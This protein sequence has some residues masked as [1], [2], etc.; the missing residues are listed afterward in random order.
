M[1]KKQPINK[2]LLTSILAISSAVFIYMF[3]LIKFVPLVYMISLSTVVIAIS[4]LFIYQLW[5]AKKIK[6][7]PI[8]KNVLICLYSL[9][10]IIASIGINQIQDSLFSL[11]AEIPATGEGYIVI[12]ALVDDPIENPREMF[13]GVIAIQDAVDVENQEHAVKYIESEFQKTLDLNAYEDVILALEALLNKECRFLMINQSYIEVLQSNPEYEELP[14]KTKEIYKVSIEIDLS[15][16]ISDT[17][18]TEEA[19]TVLISGTDSYGKI[20]TIY[21]SDVNILI[22]VNPKTKQMLIT[23]IPRDAYVSVPCWN[24]QK[25]KLTHASAAGWREPSGIN[26]L[27]KTLE[28]YFDIKIDFYVKTNFSSLISIVNAVG[29]ITIDNPYTFT[30][31]FPPKTTFEKGSIYLNGEQALQ[32]VRERKSLRN[33]DMDRN[34]HQTIVLRTLIKKSLKPSMLNRSGEL[35]EVL[36]KAY[37]TNLTGDQISSLIKMQLTDFAAWDIHSQALQGQGIRKLSA[38]LT[39]YSVFDMC[40]IYPNQLEVAKANINAIINGEK[41]TDFSMPKGIKQNISND[42]P[43]K[44]TN[45][46]KGNKEDD[47][48]I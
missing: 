40:A 34:L 19:F 8:I 18:V 28:K 14:Y 17:K 12:L 10:L 37:Q 9:S 7:K 35:L 36:S 29:G 46:K 2:V 20:P 3:S 41:I 27:I 13:D 6:I 15:Q 45:K 26:C 30:F 11:F 42:T 21:R 43:K 32:Y 24:N 33:G 48:S 39:K 4:G 25:D 23:S 31:S 38:L 5:F 22:T 44:K 16:I 47:G 1:K